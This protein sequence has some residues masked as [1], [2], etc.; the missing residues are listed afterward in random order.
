MSVRFTNENIYVQ[1]IDDGAGTTLAAAATTSKGTPGR[2]QLAANV[3]SA[4]VMLCATV[5]AVTVFRSIIRPWTISSN[6]R[7]KSR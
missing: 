7:T 5:K 6:P 1:F 3:A 2:D 4:R